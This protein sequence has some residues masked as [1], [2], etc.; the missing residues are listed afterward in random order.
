MVR[1]ISTDMDM[2]DIWNGITP[3]GVRAARNPEREEI[4]LKIKA[5]GEEPAR[6]R[7]EQSLEGRC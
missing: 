1:E 6:Q 7:A 5:C 4:K 3:K 2:Q